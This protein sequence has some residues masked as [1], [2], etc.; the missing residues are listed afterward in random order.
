MEEGGDPEPLEVIKTQAALGSAAGLLLRAAGSRWPCWLG[1]Q[2]WWRWRRLGPAAKDPGGEWAGQEV[3]EESAL[4]VPSCH[5]RAESHVPGGD[6]FHPH[7]TSSSMPPT[8]LGGSRCYW[9]TYTYELC[10]VNRGG[11]GFHS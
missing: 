8:A 11:P 7:L 4:A 10:S 5:P 2:A 6:A 1:S 3:L 9:A